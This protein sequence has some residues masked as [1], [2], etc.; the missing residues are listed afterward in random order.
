[1]EP[2]RTIE[3]YHKSSEHN[4]RVCVSYY[5][6]KM[7]DPRLSPVMKEV[8]KSFQGIKKHFV[9]EGQKFR[10]ARKNGWSEVNGLGHVLVLT[11]PPRPENP[12]EFGLATV[13]YEAAGLVYPF[14]AC[15]C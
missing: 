11:L 9:G 8:E 10:G 7:G 2:K 15:C 6:V 4:D 1:V 13:D 14:T 3:G 5:P 12:E